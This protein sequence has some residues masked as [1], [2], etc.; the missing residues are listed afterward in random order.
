MCYRVNIC[1]LVGLLQDEKRVILKSKIFAW[2]SVIS[3][4]IVW[5]FVSDYNSVQNGQEHFLKNFPNLN[6]LLRWQITVCHQVCT[7]IRTKLQASVCKSLYHMGLKGKYKNAYFIEKF[8]NRMRIT[9]VK[10][11]LIVQMAMK[12]I[13][14]MRK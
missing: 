2:N 4:E 3:Y 5:T 12:I 13:W 11:L 7:V 9:L 8:A 6:E 1:A 14:K 10:S